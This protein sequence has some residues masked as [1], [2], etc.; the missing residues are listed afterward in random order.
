M[1]N[2]A[3]VEMLNADAEGRMILAD[4][5]SYAQKYDPEL[6]I[7]MATLTG[8]AHAAVGK[9]AI[10]Y[11]STAGIRV[12]EDLEESGEEEHERLVRF[13]L[14]SEYG[15]YL[16]SDIADMKNVGG[17]T[18]GAITAGKFLEKFT[19]YP[20]VHLDI[21]GVA[22]MHGADSYRGKN[23]TGFGLRLIYNF[24]LKQAKNV[25]KR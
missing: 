11:M 25:R 19:S 9:E 20:W 12:N 10:V 2:G 4:A 23:A 16:K 21:A 22:F 7:D 17:K 1:Y 24:L 15:D 13:P 14:W 6:V 18:A 3:T 8:A 5:L